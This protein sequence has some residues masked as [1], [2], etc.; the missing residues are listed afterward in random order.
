MDRDPVT[1]HVQQQNTTVD[2]GFLIEKDDFKSSSLEEEQIVTIDK[3]I[4][5]EKKTSPI[6]EPTV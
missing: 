5:K 1:T 2:I 3:P 6:N 4:E